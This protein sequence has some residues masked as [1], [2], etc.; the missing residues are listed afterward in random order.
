MTHRTPNTALVTGGAGFIG[1]HL[2]RELLAKGL[3]VHVVDDF[4]TGLR[5][6]LEPVLSRITLFE[7]SVTDE[8]LLKDAMAGVDTVFHQAAIPSVSRSVVEPVRSHEA[9]ATGT[10]KVLVSAADAGVERFI[11]A[12]SSSAYGDTPVLP[13]AES[14]PSLPL[15]PYAVSKLTGEHY[16]KAFHHV[17]GLETVVLRYFNVFGP[18]QDPSSHYAAVIPRFVTL[19]Q[20]GEVPVINGDGEQ[21]RDFT[22]ID[23]VVQANLLAASAPSSNVAGRVFNVGCGERISVNQLWSE[24]REL[25]GASGLDPIYGPARPGDVRDSLADLTAIREAVGYSPDYGLREGLK[26]TVEWF[27]GATPFELTNV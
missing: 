25:T 6:R 3:R 8:G 19:A 15:S 22:Y 24:I 14:M 26:K 21:T 5:A 27:G 9:N 11:Y 13:K 4:S 23:N 2:T 17:H 18:G 10:L 16:C 20:R 12:G 1:H 7:G